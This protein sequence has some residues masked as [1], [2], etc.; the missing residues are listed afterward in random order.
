MTEQP[1]ASWYP[2]PSGRHELRYWDGGQWTQHVTS[3]GR[4]DIDPL[5]SGPAVPDADRTSKKIQRDVRRA[6]VAAG[7]QVGGGTLF[8]EP[9]LVVSQKAKLLEVN[10]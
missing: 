3:R 6:G 8:T 2:D 9:V 7:G 5:V 1:A 4:P 10:A